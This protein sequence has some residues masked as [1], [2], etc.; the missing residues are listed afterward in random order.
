MCTLDRL[1][2]CKFL[3][4]SS[5][6]PT[7][8]WVMHDRE[9][10]Y[11][12]KTHIENHSKTGGVAYEA[13]VYEYLT[14]KLKGSVYG[15]YNFV[16]VFCVLRGQKLDDL[17]KLVNSSSR[18][19]L[20]KAYNYFFGEAKITEVHC[21]QENQEVTLEQLAK[22]LLAST[23]DQKKPLLNQRPFV[24]NENLVE[25]ANNF[26]Y[27]V[28]V[29]ESSGDTSKTL[30]DFYTENSGN[31]PMLMCL[32]SRL[33]LSIHKLHNLGVSHND[34]HW[35]NVLVREHDKVDLNYTL[36]PRDKG[37]KEKKF[38]Y[39]QIQVS[40][41]LFDW[42]RAEMKVGRSNPELKEYEQLYEPPFSPGRDF[43]HFLRN[44]TD[45]AKDVY[46]PI[47]HKTQEEYKNLSG[48]NIEV[49]ESLLQPSCLEEPK[50]IYRPEEKTWDQVFDINIDNDKFV[51]ALVYVMKSYCIIGKRKRR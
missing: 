23:S 37:Y 46:A 29:T 40:P 48:R 16:P 42:D 25:K 34:M 1:Y 41:V 51:L 45:H 32:L 22:S 14:E 44:W 21:P 4:H 2:S 19:F 9:K 8:M 18:T 43:C 30:L 7:E 12:C 15:A 5:G 27:T 49:L 50:D 10:L 35:D 33:V 6:S 38:Q 47:A 28:V 36:S 3:E 24:D 31:T 11:Y 26:H 20:V 17:L 13:D 39:E